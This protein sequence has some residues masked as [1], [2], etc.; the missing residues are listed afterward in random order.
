MDDHAFGDAAP[1]DYRCPGQSHPIDR[2]VHLARLAT[3]YPACLECAHRHDNAGLSPLQ[4]RDWAQL[5]RR[6]SAGPRLGAEGLEG[7]TGGDVDAA[8]I[9]RVAGSLAAWLWRRRKKTAE[10]PAVLVGTDGSWTTADFVPAACR[11]LRLAG[12]RAVETGAVTSP[13]LAAAA[14]HLRAAAALW[15]GNSSG[16][17][18]A[19]NIKLWQNAGVPA[20]SP[21]GLDGALADYESPPAR[22]TRSGG[23]LARCDA[24][25]VYLPTL[26]S[27]FHGLRPLVIVLDTTCE[28]LVRYWQQLAAQAACRLVRP[29]AGLTLNRGSAA[30]Q[31]FIARRLDLLAR[32]VAAEGAH[33]GIWIDGGGETCQLI[34]D[35]GVPV[36][37]ETL[38]LL[39]ADHVCRQ[40]PGATIVVEPAAGTELQRALERSGARVC[41]GEST[42]QAMCQRMES[43]GAALGGGSG[44]YWFAGPPA[45]CDAL[46]AL[47]LLVSILSQSDRPL[48]E[49][50][51]AA[52]TAG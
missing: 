11:A 44:R 16:L 25:A 4:L 5:E 17:P 1:G 45:T 32:E 19:T 51:D 2:G 22:P 29:R 10:P 23:Q 13:C 33:L 21:G 31:P 8:L 48:S 36:P 49:V 35:R 28:V 41:R 3:F 50:L 30:D 47:S 42:R 12:C 38:L 27:L 15:V 14:Y 24:A 26:E 37:G 9:G 52:R 40:R 20:S 18:H 39:L 43:T 7:A 6:A 46:L 34:D